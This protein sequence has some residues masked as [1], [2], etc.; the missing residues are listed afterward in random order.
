MYVITLH[1]ITKQETE[2]IYNILQQS[3]L[4]TFSSKCKKVKTKT[5]GHIEGIVV[6]E[7]S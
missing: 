2:T 5:N 3:I 1:Y 6:R 4:L 7:A